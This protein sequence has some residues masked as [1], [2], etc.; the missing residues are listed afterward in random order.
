MLIY[1]IYNSN[2]VVNAKLSNTKI[3]IGLSLARQD[4]VYEI[5]FPVSNEVLCQTETIAATP[6][7]VIKLAQIPIII[8]Y[9]GVYSIIN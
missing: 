3:C 7:T 4:R 6:E 5:I 1:M 8:L 9:I 2:S